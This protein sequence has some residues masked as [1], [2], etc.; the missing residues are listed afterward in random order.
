VRYGV[1]EIARH[2][3]A[4]SIKALSD[5]LGISQNHLL[6]QFKRMVGISPKALT[7]LYR[8]KHVLHSIDPTQSVDWPLIADQANYYDQAH[9]SNDFRAFTG[10]SPTDYLR[11]RRQSHARNPERDRLLHVLPID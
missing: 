4:L 10:H 6:T 1:A 11:L 2:N 7:S 3:G 8:L 9:F 5:H